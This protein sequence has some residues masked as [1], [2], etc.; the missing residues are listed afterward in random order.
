VPRDVCMKLELIEKSVSQ[1]HGPPSVRDL[2]SNRTMNDAAAFNLARFLL[3]QEGQYGQV[4]SELRA[5]RKRSHWMWFIFPQIA[6][7]GSSLVSQHYAITGRTEAHAYLRH[8][9]LGARLAE[10]A[11]AVL[12]VDDRSA[13]DIFGFPDDLKLRSSATLFASVPA[14]GS[15]FHRVLEKY[16]DGKPDDRTL[17]L[18]NR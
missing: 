14:S 15:P 8:P 2:P 11:D 7:L 10:C 17:E 1:R 9:V 16:F 3:A 6:G 18:L 13:S 5:G 12:A 4:L